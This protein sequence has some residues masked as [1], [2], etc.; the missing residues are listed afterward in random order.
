MKDKI[1]TYLNIILP[2]IDCDFTVSIYKEDGSI[3]LSITSS[4]LNEI[5]LKKMLGYKWK[6]SYKFFINVNTYSHLFTANLSDI[7]S[8]I[9]SYEL[10]L[11]LNEE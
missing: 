3:S 10:K 11:L 2:S 5:D 8:D 1:E 4:G 9:R 7:L 6:Y